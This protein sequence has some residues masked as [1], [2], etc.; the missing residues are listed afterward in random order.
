MS[1]LSVLIDR[2]FCQSGVTHTP[3]EQGFLIAIFT[4]DSLGRHFAVMHLTA[5][6]S[7]AQDPAGL[8]ALKDALMQVPDPRHK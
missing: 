4:H 3:G 7:T 8:I 2:S 6:L 5:D 1:G